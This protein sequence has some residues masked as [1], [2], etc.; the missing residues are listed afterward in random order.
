MSSVRAILPSRSHPLHPPVGGPESSPAVSVPTPARAA[1]GRRRDWRRDASPDVAAPRTWRT[2]PSAKRTRRRT[3]S[4]LHNPSTAR[5]ARP[6]R[7][8]LLREGWTPGA[9]DGTVIHGERVLQYR[10][11]RRLGCTRPGP[12]PTPTRALYVVIAVDGDDDVGGSVS[13]TFVRI[14]R[15]ATRADN[16][17]LSPNA[18][19]GM[20]KKVVDSVAREREI[21]AAALSLSGL[22]SAS[23]VQTIVGPGSAVSPVLK[24][25]VND[26]R[27]KRF[28]KTRGTQYLV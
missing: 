3:P 16:A 10:S 21:E 27:L 11:P 14:P 25:M 19:P 15:N 4:P 22:F 7:R 5:I 13:R 9:F 2:A 8:H 20:W 26:G 1:S 6:P 18:T 23:D 24:R 17:Y 28:G 12:S